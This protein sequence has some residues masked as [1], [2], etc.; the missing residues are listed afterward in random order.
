MEVK[1]LYLLGTVY[2][3]VEPAKIMV[4]AVSLWE[5][6]PINAA[7]DEHSRIG[8]FAFDGLPNSVA[9]DSYRELVIQAIA[10]GSEDSF[11]QSQGH[12][13]QLDRGAASCWPG[14]GPLGPDP[15]TRP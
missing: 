14:P 9:L 11:C 1:S 3:P 6:E 7:P 12:V 13:R 5:G 15:A 10:M 4:F 2:D 8:W